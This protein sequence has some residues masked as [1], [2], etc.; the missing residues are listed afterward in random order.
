MR[1]I[2]FIGSDKNAGK[3][4]ALNFVYR[5]MLEKSGS[6][7]GICLTSIGIN[8]E[9]VDFFD[10]RAKPNVCIRKGS[11]FITANEHLEGYGHAY[12]LVHLFSLSSSSKN[13]MLG[14][15][16]C[17]FETV[18]EG[19]NCKG[20]IMKIKD[21]LNNLLPDCT[22]LLDGSAD[23]QFL[24]HPHVSDAFYFSLLISSRME[25]FEKAKA[26]LLPLSF[27]LSTE[28]MKGLIEREEKEETRS[29][30]F[31]E[32]GSLIYSGEMIPFLDEDLKKVCK[33]QNH[34][35]GILYL[36]GA[37]SR[38]LFSFLSPFADLEIV[39]DNFFLYQNISTDS[40]TR[41]VFLPS[42]YL[43]NPAHVLNIFIRIDED[44][45]DDAGS[46]VNKLPFPEGA[47]V[48]NLFK[49]RLNSIKIQ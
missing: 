12:D 13:Y 39:L 2:S 23:R 36:N 47:Q 34:E 41:G 21:V 26:L 33:K 42:L 16:R 15:C 30:L 35:K 17:D 20:E 18:I 31:D 40:V 24:A 27:P 6:N 11:Y 25:Q 7:S 19:P 32:S 37:L 43:L 45:N 14:R 5:K 22:L 10:G 38:S 29:L 1:T 46:I 49:D 4:T 44:L 9:D 3:T 8:G 48:Y 28:K